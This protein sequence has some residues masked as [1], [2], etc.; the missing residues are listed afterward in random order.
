MFVVTIFDEGKDFSMVRAQATSICFPLTSTKVTD[1]YVRLVDASSRD[2]RE[3]CRF[4]L[5]QTGQRS[6]MIMCNVCLTCFLKP[7]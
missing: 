2:G 5:E 6:A 7:F 3:I 4:S 1:A